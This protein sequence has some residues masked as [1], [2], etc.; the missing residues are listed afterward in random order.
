[1]D[2]LREEETL[3]REQVG[4]RELGRWV[5]P[6]I[7]GAVLVA[8]A[9]LGLFTASRARD[10][11]AYAMGF[12][13]AGLALLAL[14]VQVRHA[15]DGGALRAALP[16]VVEDATA[17]IILVA[18]LAALAVFGLLLAARAGEVRLEVTGYALFGF[19]LVF[20]FWNLKHYFDARER[21]PRG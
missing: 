19:G 17:L 12:V 6:W 14:A 4:W 18:L 20:I 11:D 10:A 16:V 3:A 21:R 15:C 1:M 8:A 2:A 5:A 7:A 9:L 13:T